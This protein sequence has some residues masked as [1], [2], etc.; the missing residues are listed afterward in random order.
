MLELYELRTN[1]M[2]SPVIDANPVFSWKMRSS[3]DSVLQKS[4]RIVV[5]KEDETFWDSGEI[6]SRNQFF[7]DY[8]GLEI[9]SCSEYSWNLTVTDNQ[10]EEAHAKAFFSTAFMK[11]SE[12]KANWVEYPLKRESASTY[13]YG[14]SYPPILFEKTFNARGRIAKA[15]VHASAHGVYRLA[16]NGDRADD[17]EF[18]P[19]FTFYEKTTYY[20]TYDVKDL[21][22]PG[23]NSLSMYVGDGWYF[24]SQA[25]P[26]L[27]EKHP[28]PSVIFQLELVYEDGSSETVISD[29]DVRCSTDFILWSDLYQGESQDLREKGHGNSI[30][31]VVRDYGHSFLKA[32]PM[33]PIRIIKQLQAE[34]VMKTPAGETVVDFGQIISGKARIRID[35]PEGAVASFDYFEVL[36]SE[37]NYINTMFAPQRDSVI[38][39]GKPFTH[40]AYFTFHGFR[41]IRVNGI[42]NVRKEDFTALL[43]S[44]EKDNHGSFRCSDPMINRLYENI[45]FS[46]YN[47]MMSIPTDCPTREKAGW[48]G[49]ILIY[50]KTA[51]LNEDMTNFLGSW[52]NSVRDCQSDDGVVKIVAPYMKL[53]ER[54]FLSVCSGFGDSSE[55]GVA[56]WSDAVV[57]VPYDMYRTTGN[58]KILEDNFQAMDRWCRYV[59]RTAREKRGS[60][61]IPEEFD[62]HLWNTGFHFGEWL[63]PSRPD[64]PGD[65]YGRCKESS[66]YIAPFF[67]YMTMR[68]M[69]EICRIL[70]KADL[71]GRYEDH[72]RIMRKSIQDGIFRRGLMPSNLMGAY[73]LAFAFDLVPED[74]HDSYKQIL[75]DLI[76]SKGDC[77][78]TGFLATPFI[79]EVLCDLGEKDLA[80]RILLQ[81]K[82]PSWLYEVIHGATTIWEAWDADDA[83]SGGRF[84]SFDHYAFGCIDS[85]MFRH[86]AG[87]GN[88]EPG[89]RRFTVNPDK[90]FGIDSFER[91]HETGYGEIKV[92][93]KGE[94][95]DVD[96]PCNTEAVV[97]WNGKVSEV[98]SGHHTFA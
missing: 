28:D 79:L 56:G 22:K 83:C 93:R 53:Y 6:E 36:S 69:S 11:S 64:I 31:G 72:S 41:Y 51:M 61:G 49:D 34:R 5:K 10:N 37:G 39:A 95:L 26:T 75:I 86:I 38:S 40:E 29:A 78:D 8:N 81:T 91:T 18:A 65:P 1:N 23:S 33:N 80:Y 43:L 82:R 17:R 66:F 55:T 12:W 70:G 77:L 74:L 88:E 76:E 3:K 13:K 15:T 50:A 4:Y 60:Y 46:Q 90:G 25:G 92:S 63:I 85:W 52:L 59:I 71:E 27:K 44:T 21:I 35:I 84:V 57:W 32:Q 47:N 42:E 9:Q 96:V 62:M 98:G 30:A 14:N 48:T 87:I 73:I 68:K 19:E 20:Q 7:I 2:E 54:L 16:I 89:F 94:T 58:R 67:G 97:F 45:R 24:S